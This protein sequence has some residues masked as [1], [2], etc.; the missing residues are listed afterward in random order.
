MVDT[1]VQSIKHPGRHAIIAE[2]LARLLDQ[3]IKIEPSAP[4]LGHRVKIRKAPREL[5]QNDRTFGGIDGQHRLM[6][7]CDPFDQILQPGHQMRGLGRGGPG[8]KPCPG[9]SGLRQECTAQV[10]Q[11]VIAL[12][13]LQRL[14]DTAVLLSLAQ[15]D[16]DQFGEQFQVF[17]TGHGRF[18]RGAGQGTWLVK[19]L[20]RVAE[21]EVGK[22][23]RHGDYR[24]RQFQEILARIVAGQRDK[25]IRIRPFGHLVN[26]FRAQQVGGTVLDLGKLRA[27]PRFQW[28]TP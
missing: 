18:Y 7:G 22:V 13:G 26:Q 8:R 10:G 23:T 4:L 1:A 2:Q 5:M 3:V 24:P 16:R 20:K 14:A 11:R 12:H 25:A 17:G 6:R 27:Y 19:K 15:Q 28:K 9:C 21:S